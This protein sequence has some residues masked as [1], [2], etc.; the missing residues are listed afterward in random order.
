LVEAIA[1][2]QAPW[3]PLAAVWHVVR[4]ADETTAPWL[5]GCPPPPEFSCIAIALAPPS[6]RAAAAAATKYFNLNMNPS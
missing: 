4:A 3:V 2:T 1:L 6:A 5:S